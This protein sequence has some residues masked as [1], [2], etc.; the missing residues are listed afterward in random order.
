MNQNL[1]VLPEM[2]GD[3]SLP[4]NNTDDYYFLQHHMLHPYPTCMN[5]Y[6]GSTMDDLFPHMGENEGANL[7]GGLIFSNGP[8]KQIFGDEFLSG[9]AQQ[10]TNLHDLKLFRKV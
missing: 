7:I 10:Q 1:G 8:H 2:T 4:P 3:R 5:P 9:S 6:M